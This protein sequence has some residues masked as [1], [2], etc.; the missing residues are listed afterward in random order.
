MFTKLLWVF[1]YTQIVKC[2]YFTGYQTIVVGT[3]WA[4]GFPLWSEYGV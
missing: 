1:K 4:K 2:Y 3:Q